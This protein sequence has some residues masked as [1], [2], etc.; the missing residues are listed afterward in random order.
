RVSVSRPATGSASTPAR[1]GWRAIAASTTIRAS[2]VT[3]CATGDPPAVPEAVTVRSVPAGPASA[4]PSVRTD[5]WAARVKP[6]TSTAAATARAASEA[7]TAERPARWRIPR[8]M[9]VHAVT[10]ALP[11]RAVRRPELDR[12]E[13]VVGGS[14]RVGPTGRYRGGEPA[15]GRSAVQGG[16]PSPDG[17]QHDRLHL[18]RRPLLPS[19]VQLAVRGQPLPVLVDGRDDLVDALPARG[20]GAHHRRPPLTRRPLAQRDHALDVPVGGVGTVPVRLVDHEDVRD[21]QDA[22]LHGLDGVAHAGREQHQGG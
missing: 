9:T 6:G 3:S 11:V 12:R 8:S 5:C 15:Q 10:I 13:D 4:S 1:A 17:F 7:T 14:V 16:D 22:G 19:P 2:P 20:H 21:L 18:R